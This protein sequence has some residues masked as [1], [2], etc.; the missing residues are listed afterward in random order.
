MRQSEQYMKDIEEIFFIPPMAVARLGGSS[1]PLAS[2]TWLEDPNLYGAGVTVIA[3]AVSLVV[4]ADGSAHPF[5]PA[6]I[7]FR[8]GNQLRP[9]AP[10]FELWAQSGGQEQ[11]INLQWL[12][13]H[14]GS[15]ESIQY[16][17]TASNRKAAR[18]TGDSA[19]AFSASIQVPG[20]D[21]SPQ[22]MLGSSSGEIPLVMPTK[23]IHLGQFQ[24]IRPKPVKSMGVDLGV[25][26]VRF[27]PASG[28]VYGPSS[29]TGV[30]L[31]AALSARDPDHGTTGP[32]HV[33]VLPENRILNPAASWTHYSMNDREDNPEPA[34]T[35]DG[36][37]D[38]SKRNR[39][40]GVVDDTCDVVIHAFL[41]IGGKSWEA[42]GRAFVAPPDYAP[43]RRPFCSLAE[44][45]VDRDPP[46]QKSAEGLP[47]AMDRL[48]DLFQRVYETASLANI[49]MTRRS[50]MPATSRG[51]VNFPGMASV[52]LGESMTHKDRLFD[53]TEDLTSPPSSHERLPLTS[54]AA[55]VHAPLADTDD[56]ALFLRDNREKVL[57]LIRPAFAHFKDLEAAV[58]TGQ[59]PNPRQRDPRILRDIEFD[60][61]MPPYMRDSDA[62]PLSLNRRQYE[63][64][65]EIVDRLQLKHATRSKTP[66]LFFSA[67]DHVDRVVKRISASGTRVS[68]SASK[69]RRSNGN[70]KNP[71]L[72]SSARKQNK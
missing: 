52:T 24:V 38:G 64:L 11:P 60:M 27:T 40:L 31:S 30:A 56:L 70:G 33:V 19:C 42:T 69:A 53:K 36:A 26:R 18:R 67:Q 9:V 10:F 50:M 61:R 54:V 37:G 22:P 62:T 6:N 71:S 28:M 63:F 21:H 16:T 44:E 15:L 49:D 41:K 55:Q 17:V 7:Q 43:D 13:A 45:L 3:P 35:Y 66:L 34:D 68:G 58:S 23:P 59:K 20:N 65:M 29:D 47:E 5:L 32:E 14:R 25:L 39:S 57:K 4:L 48:G 1:I 51:T 2:F 12:K 72:I 46:A 8:D